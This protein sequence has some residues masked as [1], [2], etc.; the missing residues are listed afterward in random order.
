MVTLMSRLHNAAVTPESRQRLETRDKKEEVRTP[1]PQGGMGSFRRLPKE[2]RQ[3]AS[4]AYSLWRELAVA[5]ANPYSDHSACLLAGR[6]AVDATLWEDGLVIL[7]AIRS[8]MDEK[9]SP[10]RI[11]EW[12]RLHGSD[13]RHNEHK[14]RRLEERAAA[15]EIVEHEGTLYLGHVP[16]V[17]G[18]ACVKCG[19]D[20]KAHRLA[21]RPSLRHVG[22]FMP[23]ILAG[24][25]AAPERT[26]ELANLDNQIQ[27]SGGVADA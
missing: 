12:A 23:S 5:R 13:K 7:E 20:L 10:R 24:L 18:A 11:P 2:L 22:D 21:R 15:Q 4:E 17:I 6:M 16:E 9:S 14:A 8:R 26:G 25:P 3:L 27:R 1:Y 19:G